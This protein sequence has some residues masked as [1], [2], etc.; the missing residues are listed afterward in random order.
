MF[1]AKGAAFNQAWATP[2]GSWKSKTSALKARLST[3]FQKLSG[4]MPSG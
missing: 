3:F 1:S 2:Q 4:A